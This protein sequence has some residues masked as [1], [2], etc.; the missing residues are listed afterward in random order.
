[1]KPLKKKISI[2]ID[3]DILEEIRYLAD[4]SFRSVSQYINIVLAE[5]IKNKKSGDSSP[6]KL[7]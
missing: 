4:D 3:E 5:H 1:M 7:L 6:T 2:T